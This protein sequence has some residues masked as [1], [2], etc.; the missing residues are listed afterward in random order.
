ME[1]LFND[2]E[3]TLNLPEMDSYAFVFISFDNFFQNIFEHVKNY[4]V[5]GVL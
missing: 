5:L 1:Y 3:I 2:I 4:G